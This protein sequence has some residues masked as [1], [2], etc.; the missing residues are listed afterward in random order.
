MS[1]D[2]ELSHSDIY[3]ALGILEGKLDAI[4]G[5]MVN[6]RA[7]LAEVF[8]RLGDAEKRIA[9]GVI[10]AIVTSLVMPVLV[11]MIGPRLEFSP[12][13]VQNSAATGHERLHP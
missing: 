8:R 6:N 5:T 10:L 9:Q 7:D 12:D 1:P 2:I 13:R 3:R 11:M 4:A